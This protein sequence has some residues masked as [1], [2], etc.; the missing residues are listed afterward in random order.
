[1]MQIDDFQRAIAYKHTILDSNILIKAFHNKECFNPLFNLL[2]ESNCSIAT[3]DLV[4]FEFTRNAYE[5]ENIGQKQK[6]LSDI[7]ALTLSIRSDLLGEALKIAKMYAHQ[8]IKDGKISLV[9][10]CLGALLKQYGEKLFL[11]TINHSDFPTCLFDVEYIFPIDTGKD[12]F[13]VIFYRFNSE[14]YKQLEKKLA[15]INKA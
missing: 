2:K 14:K 6:F 1:M 11:A 4:A 7:N 15:K 12:V 5:P 10:C 13:L 3:S 8:G 9:D